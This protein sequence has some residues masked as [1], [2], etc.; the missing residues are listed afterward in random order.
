MLAAN[1]FNHSNCK[2]AKITT[3]IAIIRT[4][5]TRFVVIELPHVAR[6]FLQDNV[7]LL[8]FLNTFSSTIFHNSPCTSFYLF[9]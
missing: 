7:A 1:N 6:H 2:S 8:L 4:I 5:I 9:T 3:I